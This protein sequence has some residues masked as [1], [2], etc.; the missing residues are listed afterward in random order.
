M[1]IYGYDFI[2]PLHSNIFGQC[3]NMVLVGGLEHV[4]FSHILGVSS[5]QLTFIFFRGVGIPPTRLQIP[6]HL[7]CINSYQLQQPITTA[8]STNTTPPACPRL[9]ASR[10]TSVHT[11]TGAGLENMKRRLPGLLDFELHHSLHWFPDV[12]YVDHQPSDHLI[13]R[14]KRPK[15]SLNP[16]HRCQTLA[17]KISQVM[18]ITWKTSMYL[19]KYDRTLE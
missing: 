13:L 7:S 16:I 15:I 18:T 19:G 12:S 14:K 3:C 17:T 8:L 6:R 11:G 4:L 5:S 10:G 9:P 1:S 2:F